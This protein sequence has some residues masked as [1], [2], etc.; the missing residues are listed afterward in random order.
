MLSRRGGKNTDA[1]VKIFLSGCGCARGNG[2][3]FC[4]SIFIK[5]PSAFAVKIFQEYPR[6]LTFQSLPKAYNRKGQRL[7]VHF[8]FPLHLT[9][10]TTMASR[11]R[12]T[13]SQWSR[14]S[15]MLWKPFLAA[16]SRLKDAP[17]PIQGFTPTSSVFL[18]KHRAGF[19]AARQ[20][21]L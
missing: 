7:C 17:V 1:A 21:W 12:K 9:G 10:G 11:C 6:F 15:R 19:H 3:M 5:P 20:F 16:G 18:W 13:L 2:R 8:F 14:S 4:G